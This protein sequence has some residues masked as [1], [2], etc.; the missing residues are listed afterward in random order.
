VQVAEN[1]RAVQA[2][3]RKGIWS[4]S[5]K[6]REQAMVGP[7]FEQMT[8]ADQ[9]CLYVYMVVV[10]LGVRVGFFRRICGVCCGAIGAI[11]YSSERFW[12]EVR[13]H[14]FLIATTICCDRANPQ[15]TRPLAKRT[16]SVLR[17][18]RRTIG[19]S[20]DLYQSGQAAGQLVHVLRASICK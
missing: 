14:T 10:R 1:M 4:R 15:T 6:P 11:P 17:W 12:E 9:V 2:P 20:A 7:R 13:S 8:M 16:R 5:Q 18:R 3:N 19:P